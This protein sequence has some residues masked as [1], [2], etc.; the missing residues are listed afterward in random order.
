MVTAHYSHNNNN[1][2]QPVTDYSGFVHAKYPVRYGWASLLLL[3]KC[4]LIIIIVIVCSILTVVAGSRLLK[5][6]KSRQ[7]LS[8]LSIFLRS[9]L[10]LIPT[11]TTTYS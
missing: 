6:S 8:F 3:L 7:R 4:G 10:Y 1:N 2:K 9:I 11:R 5:F